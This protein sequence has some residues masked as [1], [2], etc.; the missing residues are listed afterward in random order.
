MPSTAPVSAKTCRGRH[1]MYAALYPLA[2][3]ESRSVGMRR[4]TS[5]AYDR[6]IFEVQ[7]RLLAR[8][9]MG[10]VP[11]YPEFRTR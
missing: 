11:E 2:T 9:L 1:S 8:F 7:T 6:R 5:V 10:E 4:S 3:P